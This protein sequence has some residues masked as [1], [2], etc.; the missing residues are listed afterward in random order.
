MTKWLPK[1]LR[2][3][4]DLQPAEMEPELE[5]EPAAGDPETEEPRRAPPEAKTEDRPE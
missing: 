2:L 1:R 5:V 4:P 3:K